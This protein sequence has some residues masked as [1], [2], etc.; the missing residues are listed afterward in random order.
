ME[1]HLDNIN[2]CLGVGPP[3]CSSIGIL[4][5][6]VATGEDDDLD[7]HCSGTYGRSGSGLLLGRS[8]TL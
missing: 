5:G 4:E 7:N 1:L 3:E 8:G 2:L 6:I